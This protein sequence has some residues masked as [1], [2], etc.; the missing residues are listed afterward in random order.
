MFSSQTRQNATSLYWEILKLKALIGL[1]KLLSFGQPKHSA[2]EVSQGNSSEHVTALARKTNS[3]QYE[4]ILP[5][6]GKVLM[7]EQAFEESHRPLESAMVQAGWGPDSA[8][9]KSIYH[10]YIVVAP[11]TIYQAA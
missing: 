5:F 11:Q 7:D 9:G 1:E 10:K 4:V 2:R 6:A 3:G 8:V